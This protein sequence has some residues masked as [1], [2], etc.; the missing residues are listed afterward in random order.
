MPFLFGN[1]YPTPLYTPYI[2]MLISFNL[3]IKLS[4]ETVAFSTLKI[5]LFKFFV[6]SHS[7]AIS[8]F[9]DRWTRILPLPIFKLRTMKHGGRKGCFIVC[10]FFQSN[11]VILL[12]CAYCLQRIQTL[13]MSV[14]LSINNISANNTSRLSFL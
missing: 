3:S 10:R 7:F 1:I 12:L 11:V 5:S 6:V 8:S 2:E 13:G 4:I 9:F 14:T